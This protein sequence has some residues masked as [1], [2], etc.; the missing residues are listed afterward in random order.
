MPFNIA[1]FKSNIAN[2][3]LIKVNKFSLVLSPPTALLNSV[4]TTGT[5]STSLT[6]IAQQL[7]FRVNNIR[8]PGITLITSDVRHYGMGATQKQ[9]VASQFSDA[10]FSVLCDNKGNMWQFWH[11]WIKSVYQ[12]TGTTDAQGISSNQFPTYLSNYKSDYSTT[13]QIVIYDDI[14]NIVQKINLFE[15]FP[16]SLREVNLDWSD[17]STLL[18]LNLNIAYTEFTIENSVVTQN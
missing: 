13:M 10:G 5:S 1:T 12:F 18:S 3:G 16:Y 17:Q 2:T 8:T 4:L 15:A 9:P 7:S 6:T 14:G 11:N